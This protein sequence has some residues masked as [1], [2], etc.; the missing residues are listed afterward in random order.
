MSIKPKQSS[1]KRAKK[2]KFTILKVIKTK[3]IHSWIDTDKGIFRKQNI[4]IPVE[5]LQ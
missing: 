2:R 4:N 1:K 5:M 3:G